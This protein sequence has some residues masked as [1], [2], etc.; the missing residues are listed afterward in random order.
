MLLEWVSDGLIMGGR[1]PVVLPAV[2]A[3]ILTVG[4]LAALGP[5]RRGLAVEPTEVLRE[6]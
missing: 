4:L 2:A 1:A 3:V 6:E 5:A